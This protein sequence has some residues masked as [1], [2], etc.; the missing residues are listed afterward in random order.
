MP[1]KKTRARNR[2]I[3]K[4][5]GFCF[6]C[7]LPMMQFE[8]PETGESAVAFNLKA[9]SAPFDFFSNNLFV[10]VHKSCANEINEMR[11]EAIAQINQEA[12]K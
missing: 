10:A 7:W 3:V 8:Y 11:V 5:K 9:K 6:F 2:A 4:Q 12:V 1:L